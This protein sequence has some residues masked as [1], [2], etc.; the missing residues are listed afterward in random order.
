VWYVRAEA[1][2]LSV[3]AVQMLVEGSYRLP[4]FVTGLPPQTI[5]W[6]PVHTAVW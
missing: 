5:I 2:P 6:L 4:V 1:A 3:V